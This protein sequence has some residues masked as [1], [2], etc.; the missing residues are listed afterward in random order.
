VDGHYIAVSQYNNVEF[1][2]ILC[3]GDSLAGAEWDKKDYTKRED[4]R[5][6]VL[7]F[8]LDAGLNKTKYQRVFQ[9]FFNGLFRLRP[10]GPALPWG[11]AEGCRNGFFTR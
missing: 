9:R 8:T 6:F 11:F 10:G 4:L 5:E 7:R 2:Q 3:S 1:G